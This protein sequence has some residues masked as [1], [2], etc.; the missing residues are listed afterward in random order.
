MAVVMCLDRDMTTAISEILVGG[1]RFVSQKMS[2]ALRHYRDLAAAPRPFFESPAWVG[3]LAGCL[4]WRRRFAYHF[5]RPG[6]INVL[7]GVAYGTLL[8]NLAATAPSSRPVILTDSRVMLGASAK[9]RSSSGPVNGVLRAALPYVLGGDLYPGGIHLNSAENPA[10]APSRDRAVPEPSRPRPAWLDDLAAGRPARF[11][12]VIAEGT[13]PRI[14]G[15]WVRLILL[16][17]GGV[18]DALAGGGAQTPQ[19]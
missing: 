10:D 17:A 14:L 19:T 4:A 8:R 6:H 3:D 2:M 13:V 12:A 11:D 16:R 5:Q 9:G 7:E 1:P 15:R 18:P